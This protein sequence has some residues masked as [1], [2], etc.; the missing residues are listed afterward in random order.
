MS[1]CNDTIPE[2]Y[3]RCSKGDKCQ[4]PEGPILPATLEYF[5]ASK[6]GKYGLDSWCRLCRRAYSRER[7]KLPQRQSYQREWKRK[8]RQEHA[9][10]VAE[11]QRRWM[12]NHTEHIKARRKRYYQENAVA[13]R[14]AAREYHRRNRSKRLTY[15]RKWHDENFDKV[16]AY[17]IGYREKYRELMR[18]S[19]REKP[20]IHV[21]IK[22]RRRAR[23]VNLPDTFTAEDWLYALKYFDHSCAVCG[24]SFDDSTANA[25][26]WIPLSHSDCPGTVP[27]NII[28]LCGGPNGCNQS[29]ANKL[30]EEWLHLIY[31]EKSA[32]NILER[33]EE[34]IHIVSEGPA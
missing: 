10:E 27:G 2:G 18:R 1:N 26:H 13:I 25:D 16:Q 21:A 3:R 11:Y 7:E 9:K 6:K 4:H 20:E 15:K 32:Q 22:Q 17:N 5:P 23:V 14:L 12:A 19:R 28:P 29:K 24:R 31:D 8:Y 33:V 34:Y 30:P